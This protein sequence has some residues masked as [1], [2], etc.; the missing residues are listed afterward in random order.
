MKIRDLLI[1]LMAMLSLAAVAC[2]PQPADGAASG[3]EVP[4][5][6]SGASAADFSIPEARSIDG[7]IENSD[8]S[9]AANR[10]K[11][12]VLYFSFIG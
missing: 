1:F 7:N 6:V 9:L 4:S 11:A 12:T 8:F 3:V 2:G 5:S 10:G